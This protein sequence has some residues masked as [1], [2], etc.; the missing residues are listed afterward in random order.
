VISLDSLVYR[1]K[2][3]YPRVFAGL[4][5]VSKTVTV[6][7]HGRARRNAISNGEIKGT[8]RGAPASICPLQVTHVDALSQFFS[9]LPDS[10]VEYF[11]PHGF[12]ELALRKTLTSSVYACYGV[13]REEEIIAYCLIKLFPTKNAYGGRIVSPRFTG[14]GLGKY[15]WRYL[16]WQCNQIGVEPH[17]TIHADNLASLGSLRSV[18]PNIVLSPLP[19]G[20]HRIEIPISDIAAVPPELNL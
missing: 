15:L 11:R 1:I 9:S 16:I 2:R 4:A 5:A 12:G 7:R 14:I 20:Y 8:V 13:F 10:H 18:Q 6:L 17:S 3:R 19:G